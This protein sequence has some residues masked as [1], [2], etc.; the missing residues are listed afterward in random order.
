M[1]SEDEAKAIHMSSDLTD[2]E[3]DSICGGYKQNAAKVRFLRS[4][5][6]EVARKPNGRPLV[7]REHY[8]A[9]RRGGQARAEL[10]QATASGIVW[11][12]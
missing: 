9:V 12:H 7:S 2:D 8:I 10:P 1:G 11:T 3:V 6:L 5:G 4:L